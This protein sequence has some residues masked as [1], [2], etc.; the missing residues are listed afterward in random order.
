MTA[1]LLKVDKSVLSQ[2]SFLSPNDLCYYIHEYT[3]REGYAHSEANQLIHNLKISPN[4]AGRLRHK[5]S[6][7]MTCISQLAGALR[8]GIS[9][10][11]PNSYTISAIPPSKLESDQDYDDR[12]QQ[13][14]KGLATHAGISYAELVSQSSPYT[15][16]HST[17]SGNRMKPKD[18]KRLYSVTSRPP[19]SSVFIL[20]DV[21]VTGAHYTAYRDA[22]L[23]SFPDLKIIGLFVARRAI[24]GSQERIVLG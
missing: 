19:T 8:E 13:V 3:A 14:A 10:S 12:M 18:L 4:Q 11:V 22:L 24:Q 16:S 1:R 20:D 6:A 17:T 5:R 15:P 7:I 2:H 9:K 23:E 21:L